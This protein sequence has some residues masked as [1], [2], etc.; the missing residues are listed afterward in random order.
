MAAIGIIKF[1][2]S[3]WLLGSGKCWQK[4]VCESCRHDFI[5]QVAL[6]LPWVGEPTLRLEGKTGSTTPED[7][8]RG[9]EEVLISSFG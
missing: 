6:A 9:S 8:Q 4:V 1:V 7:P 3:A 2:S 5:E